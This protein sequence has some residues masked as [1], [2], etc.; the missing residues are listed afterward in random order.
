MKK[1]C[2]NSEI[3][4]GVEKQPPQRIQS[5]KAKFSKINGNMARFFC[6]TLRVAKFFF[7]LK[8]VS[9]QTLRSTAHVKYRVKPKHAGSFDFD[10]DGDKLPFIFFIGFSFFCF[11]KRRT[12]LK[13]KF[14]V[15]PMGDI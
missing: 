9:F 4:K 12:L 8:C 7:P 15:N 2:Y 10:F 6:H 11:Q 14:G 5:K 1:N 3:N 13:P